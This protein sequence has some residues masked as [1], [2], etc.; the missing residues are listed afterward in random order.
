MDLPGTVQATRL[1]GFAEIL[2]HFDK[3]GYDFFW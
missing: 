3:C 1:Q 2:I